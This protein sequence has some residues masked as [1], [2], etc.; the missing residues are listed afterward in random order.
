M[1]S[2]SDEEKGKKEKVMHLLFLIRGS[3]FI[4]LVNGQ[5]EKQR[6]TTKCLFKA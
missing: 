4:E 5:K 2:S 6:P 3:H 1:E